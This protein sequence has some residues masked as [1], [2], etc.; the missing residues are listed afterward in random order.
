M[1]YS[2]VGIYYYY[3]YYYYY[4][5][6]T[7]YVKI[8]SAMTKSVGQ[9]NRRCCMPMWIYAVNLIGRQTYFSAGDYIDWCVC[10]DVGRK[11][12]WQQLRCTPRLNVQNSSTSQRRSWTSTPRYCFVARQR[13]PPSTLLRSIYS[14][15]VA[16][17][18]F[19]FHGAN[20]QGEGVRCREAKNNK[21]YSQFSRSSP[22]ISS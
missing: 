9:R 14:P 8:H 13:T 3:Y 22:I 21:S 20:Q 11:P 17:I 4:T 18:A 15:A 7:R 12:T 10:L 2:L 5:V 16:D 1:W 19:F 6:L